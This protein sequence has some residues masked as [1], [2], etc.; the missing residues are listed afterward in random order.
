MLYTVK[1]YPSPG[2]LKWAMLVVLHETDKPMVASEI[3]RAVADLLEISDAMYHAV[4]ENGK[5]YVPY[6]L[7]WERTKSKKLGYLEKLQTAPGSWQ[8]TEKGRKVAVNK[9]R[10]FK[11]SK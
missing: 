7:G 9:K 3:D 5:K 2:I 11:N 8:L 4:M 1:D 10:L 6:R